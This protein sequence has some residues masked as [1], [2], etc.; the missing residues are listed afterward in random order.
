VLQADQSEPG[1]EVSEGFHGW[2]ALVLTGAALWNLFLF[3][4]ELFWDKDRG[5]L[6]PLFYSI[7]FAY[8]LWA[9]FQ[10]GV[11]NVESQES[12]EGS[13]AQG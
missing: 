5:G 2:V 1:T 9:H 3:L 6:L 11:R 13:E 10:G 4:A 7:I 8:T 12:T